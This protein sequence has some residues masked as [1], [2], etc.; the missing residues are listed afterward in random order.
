M[1]IL[2]EDGFQ[3]F[4]GFISRGVPEKLWKLRF[5]DNTEIKATSDH[6]FYT[7]TGWKRVDQMHQ[8]EQLSGKTLVHMSDTIPVPV[9]DALDIT[10]SHAYYTNGIISH[11]CNLIYVDE[12]AWIPNGVAEDFFTAIYPAISAGKTTKIIVTSTPRGYNYFWKIWNEAQKGIN[13]FK[14]IFVPYSEMPGR[15]DKWVTEQ[16]RILGEVKFNQE[17]LCQFLGSSKTLI[18]G[19]VLATLSSVPPIYSK[20]DLDIFVEPQK[21]HTYFIAVDV[22]KGTGGDYSTLNVIDITQTPYE[23][24]AKYRS[25]TISPL[26]FP[27]IIADVGK[28]YNMA[29]V[30]IELN[31]S[32]QVPYILRNEIE[33]ENILTTTR[34]NKR[35]QLS[36]GFGG[37]ADFQY[38]VTTD[39]FVKRTGCATLKEF[40]SRNQLIIRDMD[41]I[42]E[43]NVFV[44]SRGS[45][46]ASSGYHDDL[47]MNLVLFAW[48]TNSTYFKD[49]T[50]VDV[51]AAMYKNQ[52][53]RIQTDLIPFGFVVNGME[54]MEEPVR[55]DF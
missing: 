7:S 44:E 28:T 20:D 1:R 24:V 25:N 38:G 42:A 13:G 17:V 15:D 40:V 11:N 18:P 16:L 54:D 4:K 6:R 32:E 36:T 45:Y 14:P 35:Q 52:M 8:D 48:A 2:T 10:P 34:K 29:Y 39:I 23:Q 33:Y 9:Y 47:M 19:S 50:N 12:A 49:L 31:V 5:D 26:L 46:A 53:A 30:L 21:D 55:S 37:G 43:A 41:T 22:A 3:E 51:R 27:D